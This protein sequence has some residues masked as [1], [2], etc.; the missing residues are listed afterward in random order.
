MEELEAVK[1]K[2]KNI[3]VEDNHRINMAELE[4]SLYRDSQDSD[5]NLSLTSS[6][7]QSRPVESNVDVIPSVTLATNVCIFQIVKSMTL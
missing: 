1:I 4:A 7:C 5:D 6:N 2:Q 3:L